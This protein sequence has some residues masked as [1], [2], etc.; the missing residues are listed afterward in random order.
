ML[1]LKRKIMAVA[2]GCFLAAGAFAQKKGRTSAKT[3]KYRGGCPKRRKAA[4]EATTIRATRNH[5][6]KREKTETTAQQN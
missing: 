6:T 3:A 2:I 1:D 4:A 5:P